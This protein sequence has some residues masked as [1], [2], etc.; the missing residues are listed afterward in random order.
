MPIYVAEKDKPALPKHVQ[1]LAGSGAHTFDRPTSPL[2]ST[3]A[4]QKLQ[5][6]MRAPDQFGADQVS[7]GLIGRSQHAPAAQLPAP[8]HAD[9]HHHG[10]HS[11]RCAGKP[12]HSEH[13]E[14]ATA[15][16]DVWAAKAVK[17]WGQGHGR[18]L[19]FKHES[20]HAI[21]AVALL[22]S[23][24]DAAAN[25]ACEGPRSSR[26]EASSQ[27][28]SI[29]GAQTAHPY[30]DLVK[31]DAKPQAPDSVH[32][33]GVQCATSHARGTSMTTGTDTA[34]ASYGAALQFP[35]NPPISTA[36]TGPP[37]LMPGRETAR[38]NVVAALQR[39][40]SPSP[41]GTQASLLHWESRNR[42]LVPPTLEV[43]SFAVRGE[44]LQDQRMVGPGTAAVADLA[45][46][47]TCQKVADLT[48]MARDA[49]SKV[50]R[51]AAAQSTGDHARDQ[52]PAA[53]QHSSPRRAL[54][55]APADT[56][57]GR[58]VVSRQRARTCQPPKL[59]KD[60]HSS[61]TKQHSPKST[62][63]RPHQAHA[64][65]ALAVRDI[66]F[67][68]QRDVPAGNAKQVMRPRSVLKQRPPGHIPAIVIAHAAAAAA[69]GPSTSGNVA[70]GLQQHAG[71]PT[72]QARTATMHSDDTVR[73]PHVPAPKRQAESHALRTPP[74]HGQM[75]LLGHVLKEQLDLQRDVC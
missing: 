52:P 26:R 65:L 24:A 39:S 66:R 8:C 37:P 16:L 38:R 30:N 62:A 61:S 56:A 21:S 1:Q 2:E 63:S 18:R 47:R 23:T 25:V 50:A 5:Q 54:S 34:P 75:M 70:Q 74:S 55:T 58:S 51:S 57:R 22:A 68:A 12:E 48:C 28:R 17:Q 71:N 3:T 31:A 15:G 43:C 19:R 4:R 46:V 67:T 14:G 42:R 32:S 40:R 41:P 13:S 6:T 69:S 60:L 7:G 49:A 33:A 27:M 53:T 36:C 10:G 9:A 20:E 45:Q 44:H 35:A 64:S 29:G 72:V 11:S 73:R 59:H